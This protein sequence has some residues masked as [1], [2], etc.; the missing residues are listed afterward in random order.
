MQLNIYLS[1]SCSSL[2]S[3]PLMWW[4]E[5]GKQKYSLLY[6]S[7][8]HYLSIPASE[9]SSERVFSCTGNILSAER[10]SLA[11]ASVQMLLFIKQNLKFI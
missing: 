5:T 1:E 9:V 7:A 2:E 6:R 4:A 11:T 3:C 8:R 10:S